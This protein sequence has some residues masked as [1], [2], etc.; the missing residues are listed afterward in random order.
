MHWPAHYPSECPP[1]DAKFAEGSFF[2]L[3]QRQVPK[4]KDFYSQYAIEKKRVELNKAPQMRGEMDTC[5]AR[6]L[7]V[8]SSVEECVRARKKVASLRKKKGVVR[9]DANPS[10]DGL[11]KNTPGRSSEHHYTW[12]VP[13][14]VD[15]VSKCVCHKEEL[16][17]QEEGYV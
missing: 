6:G 17:K 10:Q 11:V 5:L 14:N 12:W 9:V 13:E 16:E 2:R 8:F 3:T 1:S 4:D 7:S 15:L